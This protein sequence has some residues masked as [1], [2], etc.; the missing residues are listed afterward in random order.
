MDVDADRGRLVSL[1]QVVTTKRPM[2]TV[3]HAI[4]R[5][6]LAGGTA[7]PTVVIAMFQRLSYFEREV[8]M[9][10]RIAATG[11]VTVVGIVEDLPPTLAPGISHVLLEEGE[12]LAAEWSVTVLTPTT[13]ATLV[14]RDRRTVVPHASLDKG[15][16]FEGG[17]SFQREDA[18]AE[19][20]RLRA[21]LA[22]R[23]LATGM[24]PTVDDVLRAVIGSPGTPAEGRADAALRHFADVADLADRESGMLLSEQEERRL[25][26]HD[27]DARTGLRT[28]RYL[29]RWIAGSAAGTLPLGLLAVR[30]HG[31]REMV[32]RYGA[33][34]EIAAAHLAG[35]ALRRH[36]QPIDRAVRLSGGDFLVLMPSAGVPELRRLHDAISADLDAAQNRFPFVPLPRSAATAVTTDRP[37][38]VQPLLQAI[39]APRHAGAILAG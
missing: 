18:Y 25:A 17:W 34:A 22:P 4:E 31:M 6:A 5:F 3:S 13:G 16:Q 8:E 36:L 39:E 11:A 15:R 20:V 30:V 21:A 32:G 24:L 33:R 12:E 1:T 35:D 7:E 37:L 26:P 38:P 23:L 2:V 10:R 14:A 9:Y 29:N 28:E 27:F 19:V